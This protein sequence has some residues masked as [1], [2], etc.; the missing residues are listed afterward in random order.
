MISLFAVDLVNVDQGNVVLDLAFLFIFSFAKNT[1]AGH[2]AVKFLDQLPHPSR[3]AAALHE[4]VHNQNVR[5]L[6]QGPGSATPSW[7]PGKLKRTCS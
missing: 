5:I 2:L 4:V 7:L 3:G 1:D 6:V